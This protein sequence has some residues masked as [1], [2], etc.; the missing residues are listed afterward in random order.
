[1]KV[2]ILACADEDMHGILGVFTS[3]ES[4]ISHFA[5]REELSELEKREIR[6]DL[7]RGY[8]SSEGV[9]TRVFTHNHFLYSIS[10]R[11]VLD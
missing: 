8:T 1:M 11:P 10:E 4:A 6:L 9:E 2:F 7:Q 3:C 5:R